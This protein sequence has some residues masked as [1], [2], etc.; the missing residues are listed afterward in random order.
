MI[1]WSALK[2]K[3]NWLIK[4]KCFVQKRTKQRCP[5]LAKHRQLGTLRPALDSKLLFVGLKCSLKFLLKWLTQFLMSRVRCWPVELASLVPEWL[6]SWRLLV[7]LTTYDGF[8]I[9]LRS[10][11][12]WTYQNQTELGL[13]LLKI[14][15][16]TSRSLKWVILTPQIDEWKSQ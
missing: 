16:L 3:F 2:I 13:K 10:K 7:N 9:F 11:S 12:N 1:Y 15:I 14:C 4:I 6:L 5:L 8:T